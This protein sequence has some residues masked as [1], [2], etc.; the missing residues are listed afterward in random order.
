MRTRNTH[1]MIWIATALLVGAASAL[2]AN[3]MTFTGIVGDA[4]CGVKHK[5]N[6]PG[7]ACT[8]ECVTHG[9]DYVLIM[10]DK[11]YTL[12]ASKKIQGELGKSAG[13]KVVVTGE[14][15]GTTIQVAAVK[16]AM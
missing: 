4:M 2:R 14:Q 8:K 15:K 7:D 6:A 9:S 12:K 5:M 10:D 16:A 1:V 13:Q 3:E 11:A